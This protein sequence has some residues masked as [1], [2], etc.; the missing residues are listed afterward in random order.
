MTNYFE[1]TR[2]R[3]A[4][5]AKLPPI[6]GVFIGLTLCLPFWALVVMALA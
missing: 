5:S 4:P 6:T 2:G 3:A 1:A